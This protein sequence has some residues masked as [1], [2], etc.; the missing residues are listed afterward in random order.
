LVAG[1]APCQPFSVAGHGR[2]SLDDRDM[3]PEFVRAVSE[4]SPKAFLLEN[5][6]GLVTPRH[7]MYLKSV[8]Q[9]L[10]KLGYN[11][12][13]EVLD[14]ALFGVPQHRRRLIV[15]G[16]RDGYFDFPKPTHG[17][18]ALPLATA[19]QALENSPADD[20]NMA[21][22]TYA[23]RPVLRRSPFAGMLVNGKGRALNLD[24]PSATIPATA[25][26][27]RT[28]II[29]TRGI[30]AKYHRH[31]IS[32]GAAREGIV[33]GVRRL[34]IRE[35]ARLQS[36][37]DSFQFTGRR[38]SQYRQVGNAVPPLLARAVGAALLA[39]IASARHSAIS[40]GWLF[41]RPESKARIARPA[42]R[43]SAR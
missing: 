32:G 39:A 3:L 40:A 9:R 29:D 2:A 36:F 22:V 7:R 21:I 1:G 10:S 6:P 35:A 26:G 34:T 11:V 15:V 30:L 4:I 42:K 41:D 23:K 31:L 38:S 37:P 5:V 17:P 14:A 28:P 24:R 18:G 13:V 25:G 16:L 19:R 43:S 33:D 8:V 27:N 12:S 20:P